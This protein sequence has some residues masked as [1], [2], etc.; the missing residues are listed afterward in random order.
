M[1]SR[2]QRLRIWLAST[3]LLLLFIVAGFYGYARYRVHKVLRQLPARLGVEIEQSTEGFTLSKSEG[4]RTLFTI[5]ASKAVRYKEAGR[6]ELKDVNIVVYGPNSDRFDQIYGSDFEYDP[7]SGNVSARGEV[8]ID[9]QSDAEGPV[10]PDQAPPEELKNPIHLKTSGVVFN[11]KSGI[12]TTDQWVEFHVPQGNGSAVGAT[13]DSKTQIVTL[14]SKVELTTAGP[15]HVRI[16]AHRAEFSQQPHQARLQDAVIHQAARTVNAEHVLLDLRQ[17]NTV[18]SV[19]A[20][21]NVHSTFSGPSPA[22]LNASEAEFKVSPGNQLQDGVL[23]GNVSFH[24]SGASPFRGS[25]GRVLLHFAP[26]DKIKLIQARESVQLEQL[27]SEKSGE[28]EKKQLLSFLG[29]A[30]DA[31]LRNGRFMQRAVTSGAAQI[32]MNGGPQP[33]AAPAPQNPAGSNT[34]ITAGKF[35]AIF[36]SGNQI[37][38]LHGSPDAKIVSTAPGQPSRTSTSRELLVSFKSGNLIDNVLQKGDV[39]MQDDQRTGSASQARFSPQADTLAMT[40]NVRIQDKVSSSSM[41]ADSALLEQRTGELTAKGR[42][43]TTYADLKSQPNGAMLGSSDPIHVTASQMTAQKATGAA[44]YSGDSRLW[45]EGNIV[46]APVLLFNRPQ[47]SL[48]ATAP[49]GG[50]QVSCIFVETDPQGRQ[51][52]VEVTAGKLTYTDSDRHARFEGRVIAQGEN[53]TF[54]ADRLD[55]LLKPQGAKIS[56]SPSEA[57]ASEIEQMEAL[58]HVS[59]DQPERRASGDHLVYTEADGKFVLTGKPGNPPSIFDAEQGKVTGDSLTF[60]SR[61]DRVLVGSKDSR[62][63]T[64]TRIKK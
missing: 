39:R 36:A 55:I 1:P 34:V 41:S 15:Q 24:S 13:Y 3:A 52:P 43:K 19:L 27:P 4:G 26:Q 45:Q 60:F 61:D 38:S 5:H 12:A 63:V 58:G 23:R 20:S 44:Q 6:A 49:S 64:Q 62:T 32:V 29:D 56:R 42:V 35:E 16:L 28:A 10:R 18:E 54:K 50:R 30:L 25:A 59:V 17:N 37:K 40:G 11:Q 2:I 9:L 33:G 46:Q 47:R 31:E 51:T 21:G 53:G 48:L 14:R 57:H 7:Q 22:E 8:H